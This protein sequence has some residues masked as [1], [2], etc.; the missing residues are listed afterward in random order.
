[1]NITIRN[2]VPTSTAALNSLMN[3][4]IK[5]KYLGK[6]SFLSGIETDGTNTTIYKN[7][8]AEMVEPGNFNGRAEFSLYYPAAIHVPEAIDIKL[9]V[10][11]K[12]NFML[13]YHIIFQSFN[14]LQYFHS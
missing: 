11:R 6:V 3:P 7:L 10:R 2:H 14:H 4:N 8:V 9:K 5:S 13:Q 1:M 12:W